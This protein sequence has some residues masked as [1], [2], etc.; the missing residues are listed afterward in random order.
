MLMKLKKFCALPPAERKLLL[1]ALLCLPLLSLAL[2]SMGFRRLQAWLLR[3][4]ASHPSGDCSPDAATVARLVNAA[5]N[6]LPGHHTCLPR[7]LLLQ[8]LL[9]R[10]GIDC[11][12]MIGVRKLDG[13]LDAHAWVECSGVPVNDQRGVAS[14]YAVFDGP[15][16]ARSFVSS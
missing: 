12:L 11:Q 10:G 4:P 3:R 16:A 15:L 13:R 6:N 14:Q 9:R 8:F 5:A 1:Q 2:W 7:S